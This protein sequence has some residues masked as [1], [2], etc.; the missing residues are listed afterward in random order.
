MALVEDGIDAF[1]FRHINSRCENVAIRVARHHGPTHVFTGFV[2][3]DTFAIGKSDHFIRARFDLA[4]PGC[5]DE[6]KKWLC[7]Y[8]DPDNP[9]KLVFMGSDP[10]LYLGDMLENWIKHTPGFHAFCTNSF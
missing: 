10:R 1:A 6:I 7:N 8:V 9:C 4:N 2:E 5:W 3:S